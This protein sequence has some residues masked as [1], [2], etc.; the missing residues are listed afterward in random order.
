L[1]VKYLFNLIIYLV[2]QSSF[3][4]QSSFWQEMQLTQRER[5]RGREGGRKGGREG[6]RE[7]GRERE[8]EREKHG[9]LR[10]ES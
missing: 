6:R 8:R 2:Q 10:F 9:L 7:G 5:E 3:I 4:Y 1:K